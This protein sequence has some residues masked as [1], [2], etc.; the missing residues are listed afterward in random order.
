V[1]RSLRI[2]VHAG[3]L[4]LARSCPRITVF[5]S[6]YDAALLWHQSAYSFDYAF[7]EDAAASS[8]ILFLDDF[9]SRKANNSLGIILSS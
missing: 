7:S 3:S 9:V 1:R 6:F 8:M 5:S 2:C 4:L